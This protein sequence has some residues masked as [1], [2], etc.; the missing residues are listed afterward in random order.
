MRPAKAIFIAVIICTF[1]SSIEETYAQS[2]PLKAGMDYGEAR[3]KLIKQG[4]Q[5]HVPTG[6]LILSYGDRGPCIY[7]GLDSSKLG[8][9]SFM[10]REIELRKV[11]RSNGW[12]EAIHCYPTGAGWCHHSF[13]NA[14]GKKLIVK[15]GSGADKKMPNVI[16]FYFIPNR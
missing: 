9:A 10:N 6:A 7:Q 1:I 3:A 15:T 16:E 4:W 12:Y 14:Y 11:F 5:P 13:A 8:R 2:L